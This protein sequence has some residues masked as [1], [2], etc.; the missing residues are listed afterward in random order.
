[1]VTECSS[2]L[3]IKLRAGHIEP[4]HRADA[5]A[6]FA[7]LTTDNVFVVPVARLQFRTAARF[8]DQ[9]RLRLRA[10][11]ALHLTVRPSA[12][13]TGGSAMLVRCSASRRCCFDLNRHSREKRESRN[14]ISSLAQGSRTGQNRYRSNAEYTRAP[15]L[16]RSGG[17]LWRGCRRSPG[18]RAFNSPAR[19][20]SSVAILWISYE[21]SSPA[22]LR[23]RGAHPP[24]RVR[25]Q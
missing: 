22:R 20:L 11:D 16:G 7:R 2:A 5:L 8:A 3:S 12:P 17:H 13:S 14:N 15:L 9:H 4:A 1:M 21:F 10:G 6:M 24:G 23:G 18:A 19:S 25:W